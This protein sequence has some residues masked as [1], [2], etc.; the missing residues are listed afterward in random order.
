M[1]AGKQLFVVLLL[2]VGCLQAGACSRTEHAG[3]KS[4]APLFKWEH[5]IRKEGDCSGET[6]PCLTVDLKYPVVTGGGYAIGQA[7]DNYIHDY[8][9]SMLGRLVDDTTTNAPVDT[10][11][12]MIAAAHSTSVREYPEVPSQW[13][14]E[15]ETDISRND[16][17]VVCVHTMVYTYMGGAHPLTLVHYASFFTATGRRIMPGDII[18]DREQFLAR[19]E[20]VFRRE[21]DLAPD[22]DLDSAGFWFGEKGFDIPDNMGFTDTTLVLYYNPYEIAPYVLGSTVIELP[23][24]EL[25]GLVDERI[26]RK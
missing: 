13:S 20:R 12:S 16:S 7:V 15:L 17:A 25:H 3:R 23:Y 5:T 4:A 18:L 1:S 26:L 6:A 24:T 21:Y 11:I 19:A 22:A 14:V 8:M 2:A 10:L 9:R